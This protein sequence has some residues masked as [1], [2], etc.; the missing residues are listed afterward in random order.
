MATTQERGAG[1]SAP[2]SELRTL[3]A[4]DGWKSKLPSALARVGAEVGA[5]RCYV[6]ENMR[7]P[8]GRLW[9]D[10]TAE[11]TANAV[12]SVFVDSEQHLHPYFPDFQ[13]WIDV[14]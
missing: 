3:L 1:R 4:G 13:G 5:D 2:G 12:P 6:F 9:M 8:D 10:L 14:L 11:W 7:G